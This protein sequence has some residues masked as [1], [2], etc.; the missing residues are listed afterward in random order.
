MANGKWSK[1][2]FKI[3]DMQNPHIY[4]Q[5]KHFALIVT[6]KRKFMDENPEHEGFFKT[7]TRLN[8]YHS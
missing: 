6:E 3:Y 4:E 7:R 1:E 2:N 8:S 5:F